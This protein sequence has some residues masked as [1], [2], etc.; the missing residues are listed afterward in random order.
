MRWCWRLRR[1]R[2]MYVQFKH[3]AYA[4]GLHDVSYL[5]PRSLLSSH[6][7]FRY[8]HASASGIQIFSPPPQYMYESKK[9][10]ANR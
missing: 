7:P 4:W 6:S 2:L 9:P 10:P 5:I 3:F 1:A 8:N